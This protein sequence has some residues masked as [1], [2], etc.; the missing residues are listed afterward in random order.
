MPISQVRRVRPLDFNGRSHVP[1][2]CCLM[3]VQVVG[4]G[5]EGPNSPGPQEGLRRRAW[6][7][8]LQGVGLCLPGVEAGPGAWGADLLQ[9]FLS[10]CSACF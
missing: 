8:I 10:P 9:P 5:V 2:H 4:L 3:P 1:A 7:W 6:V